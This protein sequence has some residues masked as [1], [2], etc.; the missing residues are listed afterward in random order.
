M[1]DFII[2]NERKII[3][4]YDP[5]HLIKGIRN[6]LLTKNLEVNYKSIKQGE[7]REI[8]SWDIIERAYKIDTTDTFNRLMP[9]ITEEHIIKRKIKKMRVKHAVQTLSRSMSVFINHHT[10]IEGYINTANGPLS[11]PKK[12]GKDTAG[13]ILFFNH[14]FDSVNGHSLKSKEAPLRIAITDKTKHIDFWEKAIKQLEEMRFVDKTTGKPLYNSPT[15]RNWIQTI[16]GFQQLWCT[17]KERGFKTL[18]PRNINQDPLENF[19]GQIRTFGRANRNPTCAQFGTYYKALLITNLTTKSSNKTN[20]E[21]NFNGELLVSLKS[22]F[23]SNETAQEKQI[24]QSAVNLD[25]KEYIDEMKNEISPIKKHT[26]NIILKQILDYEAIKDCD[27]CKTLLTR[28]GTRA[29]R[30]II[31]TFQRTQSVLNEYFKDFHYERN[32]R[33]LLKTVCFIEVEL[34]WIDCTLHGSQI[35]D[36]FVEKI[37]QQYFDYSCEKVN[38]ILQGK[39]Q[40]VGRNELMCNAKSKYLRTLKNKRL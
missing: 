7:N 31:T 21:E 37:V 8:A 4:L 26:L 25:L 3:P 11:M 12:E 2:L 15:I 10:K 22:I 9:K 32:L 18:R 30:N 33:I 39:E 19:F 6:N 24:C 14:L 40:Y 38:K 28:D 1:S 35:K 34:V 36:V 5:P 13:A 23:E 20:C 27:A 17:L 16:R 29:S